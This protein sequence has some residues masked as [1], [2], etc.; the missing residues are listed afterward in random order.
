MR[1]EPGNLH[2]TAKHVPIHKSIKHHNLHYKDKSKQKK[3]AKWILI[4]QADYEPKLK[5]A[6]RN[7]Q[8]EEKESYLSELQKIHIV[9]KFMP[10]VTYQAMILVK[11]NS[12]RVFHNSLKAVV[13]LPLAR[14]DS[15][16]ATKAMR[17]LN[18]SLYSDHF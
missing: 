12:S 3:N 6:W 13:S 2:G 17:T 1:T 5:Y 18:H 15:M 9:Q 14:I 11:K 16:I 7:Q 4:L 10:Q 8:A